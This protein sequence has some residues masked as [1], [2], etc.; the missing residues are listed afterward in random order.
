[1]KGT[2]T[3]YKMIINRAWKEPVL[4]AQRE[5]RDVPRPGGAVYGEL[6]VIG[7]GG[8]ESEE[9][10]TRP[11]EYVKQSVQLCTRYDGAQTQYT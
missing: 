5:W 1:M 2:E 11:C 7:N 3:P 10:R 4:A 8:R 9:I 6:L